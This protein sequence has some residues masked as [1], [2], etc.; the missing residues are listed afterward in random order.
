M[1]RFPVP[2][3]RPTPPQVFRWSRGRHAR[4]CEGRPR[5]RLTSDPL[6]C[7]P[8]G[9]LAACAPM[10]FRFGRQGTRSLCRSG[11]PSS[12]GR[13]T[14]TPAGSIRGSAGARA[15]E[16][17]PRR[18]PYHRRRGDQRQALCPFPS[19]PGIISTPI[20]PATRPWAKQSTS[21][22]SPRILI[23]ASIGPEPRPPRPTL[24]ATAPFWPP[25]QERP[26]LREALCRW[27]RLVSAS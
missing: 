27:W 11:P 17:V 21:R 16:A 14:T 23:K 5:G 18:L 26:A 8:P 20:M 6:H 22:S 25:I 24:H 3:T 19:C 15:A 13:K 2:T 12:A 1:A 10:R 4:S 9:R 7:E